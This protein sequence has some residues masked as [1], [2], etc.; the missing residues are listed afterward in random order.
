MNDGIFTYSDI[1]RHIYF[2]YCYVLSRI[3]LESS[4]KQLRERA[5]RVKS[6][7]VDCED[8]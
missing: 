4:P 6:D 8:L 1:F 2:T 7:E 5:G 3:S